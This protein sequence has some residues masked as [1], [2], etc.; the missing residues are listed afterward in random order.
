[1][2]FKNLIILL[3]VF[4]VLVGIVF[5]KK[6]MEPTVP[7]TEEMADIITSSLNLENLSEAVFRFGLPAGQAGTTET[8]VHL[9]KEEGRWKVKSLYGVYADENALTAFLNKLNGL[10]GELRSNE[11]G[12]LA[13]YGIADEAGVHIVLSRDGVAVAHLVVGSKR[14]GSSG[15]FIRPRDKNE[16]YVVEE[17]LLAEF[18]LWGEP[19]AENFNTDKWF[20]KQVVRFEPKD[21]VVFK[22][23]EIRQGVEKTWL[24]L[25]LKTA[26]DKTKWESHIPYTFGLSAAKIKNQLQNLQNIRVS[27]VVAADTHD[28]LG[29][30]FWKVELKLAEGG[31]LTL[32]RSNKDKEGYNYYVKMADDH[33][34]LVPVST[35]DNFI[36]NSG[37]ILI[38]NPLEIKDEGIVK[39]EIQDVVAKKTCSAGRAV[40]VWRGMG[41]TRGAETEQEKKEE[42]VWKT[43]GGE[44]ME[45]GKV[46]DIIQKFKNMNLSLAFTDEVPANNALIVKLSEGEETKTYTLA[47]NK[48]MDGGRDCHFLKTGN[49]PSAYCYLK[50]DIGN[51]KNVIPFPP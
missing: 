31:P 15:N 34:F 47:E 25:E 39:V 19:K 20:D 40:R 5:V 3:A 24:D 35:F 29:D 10:E 37:D 30:S 23:S 36:K 6:G 46:E 14:S 51:F 4:I 9:I 7:T 41:E 12:L 27:K 38:A 32:V 33:C 11:A 48:A 26:D 42:S 21:A 18:G 43:S 17:D 28:A 22:I 50:S 13:D 49:D 8:K 16:V 1:M 2:K 45:K 44:D